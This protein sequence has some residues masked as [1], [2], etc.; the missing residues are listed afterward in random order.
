MEHYFFNE[1][2][3]CWSGFKVIK[4]LEDIGDAIGQPGIFKSYSE[5]IYNTKSIKYIPASAKNEDS[6]DEY[7]FKK[8]GWDG[9][10]LLKAFL[11]GT[12]L[13]DSM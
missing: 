13:T 9:F 4:W 6:V 7:E 3:C 2:L 11:N 12:D 10:K 5:E 8:G 1:S